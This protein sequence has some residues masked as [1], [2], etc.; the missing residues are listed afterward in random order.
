MAALIGC[1]VV[2]IA[3]LPIFPI[4]GIVGRSLRHKIATLSDKRIQIM[5]ELVTG[6]QVIFTL[7]LM[8]RYYLFPFNK[9]V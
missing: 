1:G 8:S 9:K 6:I 2:I 4:M 5:N 3:S 7:F